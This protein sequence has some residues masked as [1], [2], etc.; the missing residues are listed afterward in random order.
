[1]DPDRLC[2]WDEKI[3][4]TGGRPKLFTPLS[5]AV[6]NPINRCKIYKLRFILLTTMRRVPGHATA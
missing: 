4:I 3:G 5:P 2:V 1:M 6:D